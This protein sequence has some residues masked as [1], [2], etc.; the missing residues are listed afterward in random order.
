MIKGNGS[1][2]GINGGERESFRA[3]EAKNSSR[4][5]VGGEAKG[6]EHFPLRKMTLN[7][8]DVT[9]EALQ[10][11][12]HYNTRE[13][14]GFCIG[15]HSAQFSPGTTAGRAEEV[16]PNRGIDQDQM[17]FLRAAL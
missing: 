2:E 1:N 8:V 5:A 3:P 17:R 9:P 6:F 7:L 4:L 13:R 10:D 16:D 12:G 11:L 14:K 15:N